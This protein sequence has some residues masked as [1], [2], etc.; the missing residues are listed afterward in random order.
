MRISKI[1][2]VEQ[3]SGFGVFGRRTYSLCEER[4]KPF[5]ERRK[6]RMLEKQE[7]LD[8]LSSGK[9]MSTLTKAVSNL[10]SGR[11][12]RISSRPSIL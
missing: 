4:P 1:E 7:T 2:E 12:S 5:A 10:P 9:L 6:E 8:F 3:S 11:I